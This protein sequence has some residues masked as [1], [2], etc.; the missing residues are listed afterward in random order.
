MVLPFLLVLGDESESYD[1]AMVCMVEM[2]KTQLVFACGPVVPYL[3]RQYITYLIQA[4]VGDGNADQSQ[5]KVNDITFYD[6]T[7]HMSSMVIGYHTLMEK[8]EKWVL[9]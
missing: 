4:H 1:M 2:H 7:R 3:A 6:K 5:Y 9:V 8:R